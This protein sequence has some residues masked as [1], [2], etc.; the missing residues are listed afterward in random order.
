MSTATRKSLEVTEMAASQMGEIA[1]TSAGKTAVPLE[2]GLDQ[3]QA[4]YNLGVDTVFPECAVPAFLLPT[5][6]DTEDYLLMFDLSEILTNLRS[7]V[8][9]RPKIELWAARADGYDTDRLAE[10][11]AVAFVEQFN[12]ARAS[13]VEAG[14]RQVAA[15]QKQQDAASREV[16]DEL[17]G[18]TLGSA[19]FWYAL[20]ATPVGML[21]LWMGQRPR[22]EIFGLTAKYLQARSDKAAAK[23]NM[24]NEVKALESEFDEKRTAFRRAVRRMTIRVHPRLQ[25][26]SQ[27]LAGTGDDTDVSSLSRG[28]PNVDKYLNHPLYR[29]ALPQP[30]EEVAKP[31]QESSKS[32]GLLKRVFGRR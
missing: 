20:G 29:K 27:R 1:L 25:Q 18:P 6:P 13:L 17:W 19:A 24:E 8:L 5:G 9:V 15:Y 7:G 16:I 31:Q 30:Q 14:M 28:V 10:E 22:I 21:L 4:L 32:T 2:K 23:R 12:A 3:I 26:V 11:L